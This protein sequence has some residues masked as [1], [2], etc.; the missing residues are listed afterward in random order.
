M[1]KGVRTTRMFRKG[2]IVARY[3]GDLILSKTVSESRERQYSFEGISGG[4][5]FEIRVNDKAYWFVLLLSSYAGF[6]IQNIYGQI[7]LYNVY[8]SNCHT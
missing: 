8:L 1:N 5:I 3:D 4:H 2:E 6:F 7:Y